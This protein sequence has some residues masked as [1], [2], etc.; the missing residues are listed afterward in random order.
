MISAPN[1]FYFA[2]ISPKRK[3]SRRTL[4]LG[5]WTRTSPPKT[6]SSASCPK[7]KA[8]PGRGSQQDPGR[9]GPRGREG[10]SSLQGQGQAGSFSRWGMY[11]PPP[12]FVFVLLCGGGFSTYNLSLGH[13]CHYELL[14]TPYER[15]SDNGNSGRQWK[16]REI[17]TKLS[18][19]RTLCD[20][21]IT[22]HSHTSENIPA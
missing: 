15:F 19:V 5:A 4:R 17:R 21:S 13:K 8:Q 9:P 12:F 22:Y 7:E 3:R 11:A 20:R 16:N 18:F 14:R 6:R 10:K 2:S 1:C